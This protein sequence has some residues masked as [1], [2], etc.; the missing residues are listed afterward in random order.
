MNQYGYENIKK[1]VLINLRQHLT[2][3]SEMITA[4]IGT[5]LDAFEA[6]HI[7]DD[8]DRDV[9]FR[10]IFSLIS[11]W[12][13]DPSVLRDKKHINWVPERKSEILKS[14]F[15]KRYRQYLEEEKNWSSTITTKLDQVTDA[16]LGDIGNPLQP[17]AWDRRG[18]VVGDV[19]SGKT[20]NYTGLICKATDA[21]YKLIIVLAGMTNDLR[22]QTPYTNTTSIFM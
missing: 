16:I 10:D 19:Q 8:I 7:V 14:G 1:M 12:Q 22:S 17:G 4:E 9:L 6:A 11:V 15:W 2:V 21:G 5:L 13:P 20:A 18:M 3:T